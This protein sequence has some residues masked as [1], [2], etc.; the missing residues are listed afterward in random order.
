MRAAWARRLWADLEL[1]GVPPVVA[2]PST[3]AAWARSGVQELTGWPDGPALLPDVPLPSCMDGAFDVLR[4]LAPGAG[5]R[6]IDGAGLLGERAAIAGL[7]RRGRISPGGSCRLLEAS[8]GWLAV[9][10][11]RPDDLRALPAW[12]GVDVGEDPWRVV[13]GALAS[14]PAGEA[15]DRARLLGLAVAPTRPGSAVAPAWRRV[16]DR[17]PEGPPASRAPRVVDLSSLWAGPLCGRL[18]RACGATVVRVESRARPDGARVGPPA[19][20]ERMNA[21]KQYVALDFASRE[22]RAALEDLLADADVVIEASRPRALEQLGIDAAA[23]IRHRPGRVWLSLTAYGLGEP[24]RHW[25][26]FGDDVAA[27]AGLVWHVAGAPLFVADAVADPVAG[28]HAAVAVLAARQR[29]SSV[30]LDVSLHA[31]ATAAGH[32]GGS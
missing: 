15:A 22:G 9:N 28:L 24:Q 7:R 20:F 27:A 23:W 29:G 13:A 21:G 30:R 19:F 16:D 6:G 10:L 5:L 17:G 32:A 4:A 1:A 12:L 25:V 31:V 26:G 3:A 11:P 8:D 18:L 14:W 2:E